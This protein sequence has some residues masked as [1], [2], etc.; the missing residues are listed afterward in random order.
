MGDRNIGASVQ[1]RLKKMSKERGIDMTALLRRFA[2]ERLLYR[3]SVS[4]EAGNFCVKG[5]I[6]L[7]AYNQ[8]DLL[9]PTED[10][11]LNG[12]DENA[13]VTVLEAA[14]RRVLAT[15]VDDDGVLF[16]P[17]TIKVQK[18]RTGRIPGGKIALMATVHTSKVEVRVDVGFGNPVS[19]DVRRLVMPTL[20]EG[21]APR[22]EVLAYPLETVIAEKVHAMA[23]FGIANTRVKDY[24]DIWMLTRTQRFDGNLLVEAVRRTFEAQGRAIPEAP[25]EGLEED[26]AEEQAMT[27]KAFLKRI[28]AKTPMDLRTVVSDVAELVLPVTEAA[29]KGDRHDMEWEPSEGWKPVGARMAP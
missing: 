16:F 24:F 23:Q 27:W 6:L 14:L 9:R 2:Q 28:D 12:F 7:S 4:E 19:P 26:Y 22:P 1:A 13:D 8:G 17:A 18:D 3:L 11:D 5:G 25:F 20:L 29:R 15:D 10:I 21:V